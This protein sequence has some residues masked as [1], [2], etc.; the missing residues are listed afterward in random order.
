M[1]SLGYLEIL[2]DNLIPF[3]YQNFGEN[4]RLVQDNDSK[5]T[6]RAC[7][8]VLRNSKVFWVNTK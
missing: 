4:G 8:R 7:I 3:S 2:C 1:D 6:A 5:H